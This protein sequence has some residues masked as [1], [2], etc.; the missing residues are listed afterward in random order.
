MISGIGGGY[1][2]GQVMSGASMPSPPSQKMA[3]LFDQI[4]S[5]GSGSITEAQFSAA[6][7]ANNPPA[8]V[9]AQGAAAIYQQLDPTNSGSVSRSDFVNGMTKILAGLRG[10]PSA[11]SAS[12]PSSDSGSQSLMDSLTSL[13]SLGSSSDNSGQLLDLLA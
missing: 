10:L 3:N 12:S 6:F 4:D 8:S 13:N 9:R 1:S 7:S 5:S 11:D 2:A